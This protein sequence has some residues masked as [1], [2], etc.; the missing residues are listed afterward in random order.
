MKCWGAGNRGQLGYGDSN[1]RGDGV[2]EMGTNLAV[3]ELPSDFVPSE[4]ALGDVSTCVLSTVGNV[5]CFGRNQYGQLGLGH[6]N[7]IGDNSNEMGNN[8]N[9]VSLGS[10]FGAV[11]QIEAMWHS[12]CALSTEGRLKCWGFN[13]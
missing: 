12:F 13:A 9:F 8:L 10:D 6:T 5:T 1:T 4:M 2:G 3:V 7:S 11:K